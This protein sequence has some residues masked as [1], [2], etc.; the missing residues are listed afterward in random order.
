MRLTSSAF[1]EGGII[2][3]KYTCE[4]EN[5]S[6][7]LLIED[8]PEETDSLVLIL[9]DP[10]SPGDTWSHWLIWNI[11]PGQTEF[12]EGKTPPGVIEGTTSFGTPGYGGPC[13]HND[14][15]HHYRFKLYALSSVLNSLD[16]T[17]RQQDLESA[18]SN[19]I[20]DQTELVGI[21]Q[22]GAKA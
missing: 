12:E 7:P 6:P 20:I 14:Q 22:K 3:K 13:P 10:D 1:V 5:I 11:N 8:I 16:P 18:M 17:S 9:D 2:P 19:C 4:G 21:F 15:T